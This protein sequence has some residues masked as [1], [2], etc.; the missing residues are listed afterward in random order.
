[1]IGIILWGALIFFIVVCTCP[2]FLTALLVCSAIV[3]SFYG[4]I[5][6]LI[7]KIKQHRNNC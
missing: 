5:C 3:L 6:Y 1:M 7:R 4:L 2:G